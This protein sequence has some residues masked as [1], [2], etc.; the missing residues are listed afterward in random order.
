MC[1][2]VHAHNGVRHVS[3]SKKIKYSLNEKTMLAIIKNKNEY[4]MQALFCSVYDIIK[5]H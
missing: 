5:F 2:Y 1:K 3:S 4:V